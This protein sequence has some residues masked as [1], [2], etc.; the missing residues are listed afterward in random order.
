MQV[1]TPRDKNRS[2]KSTHCVMAGII[3]PP[4][5]ITSADVRVRTFLSFAI[6]S[7]ALGIDRIRPYTILYFR[8]GKASAIITSRKPVIMHLILFQK[9]RLHCFRHNKYN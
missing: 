1:A 8:T 3:P 2:S 5:S 7:L 6:L 9:E 4:R